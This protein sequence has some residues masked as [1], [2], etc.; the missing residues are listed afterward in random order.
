MI[1][2]WK[3]NTLLFTQI[4][5]Y[6]NRIS[7]VFHNLHIKSKKQKLFTNPLQKP[8]LKISGNSSEKV[9]GRVLSNSNLQI[10]QPGTF[11]KRHLVFLGIF[12]NFNE[13][14]LFVIP[15]DKYFKKLTIINLFWWTLIMKPNRLFRNRN[16]K[17]SLTL[18]TKLGWKVKR[19]RKISISHLTLMGSIGLGTIAIYKPNNMN[20]ISKTWITIFVADLNKHQTVVF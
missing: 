15:K 1:P 13:Q 2:L 18:L 11:I 14:L 3:S 8:V 12:W 16:L 17:V 10:M 5:Q 19:R 4:L 6:L 9:L 7:K 20:T